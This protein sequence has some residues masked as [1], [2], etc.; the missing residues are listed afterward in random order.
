MTMNLTLLL[1]WSIASVVRFSFQLVSIVRDSVLIVTQTEW[2]DRQTVV[3]QDFI[4]S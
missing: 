3:I 1:Q 4:S 2:N